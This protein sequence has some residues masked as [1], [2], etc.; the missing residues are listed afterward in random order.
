MLPAETEGS[1]VHVD[2]HEPRGREAWAQEQLLRVVESL[3]A[4]PEAVFVGRARLERVLAPV[5]AELGIRIERVEK[6][7]CVRAARDSLSAY[8]DGGG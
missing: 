4:R 6:L 8:L 5:A 1:I 2:L 7:V 3:G